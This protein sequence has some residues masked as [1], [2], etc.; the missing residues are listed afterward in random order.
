MNTIDGCVATMRG[1]WSYAVFCAF[2]SDL[3]ALDRVPEL[4]DLVAKMTNPV[5]LERPTAADL[6]NHPFFWS[7]TTVL[8]F[9]QDVSDALER[10]DDIDHEGTQTMSSSVSTYLAIVNNFACMNL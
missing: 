3:T 2:C 7:S 5:P 10:L 6:A 9:I 8:N 1:L 4:Q